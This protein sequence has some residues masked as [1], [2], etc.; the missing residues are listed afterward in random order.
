MNTTT[1]D[2]MIC[3]SCRT[4][5]RLP[6]GWRIDWMQVVPRIADATGKLQQHDCGNYLRG[7]RIVAKAGKQECGEKCISAIGPACE[8]KCN[9]EN[10][11][12]MAA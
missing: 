1:A 7:Q 6:E 12:G 3:K 11:G 5:S 8:C 4:S 9:G 2:R 10:H